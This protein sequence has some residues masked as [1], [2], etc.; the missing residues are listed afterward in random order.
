MRDLDQLASEV[1]SALLSPPPS[2]PQIPSPWGCMMYSSALSHSRASWHWVPR[3]HIGVAPM[4]PGTQRGVKE[5]GI[6]TWGS[7][8]ALLRDTFPGSC[9]GCS[10]HKG[11]EISL[12]QSFNS[13][14]GQACVCPD[15]GAHSSNCTVQVNT[16]PSPSTP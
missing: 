2:L 9:T 6:V 11:W 14:Q 12:V 1:T 16:T 10:L 3:G 13:V 4:W 8:Q 15:E 7:P 5:E